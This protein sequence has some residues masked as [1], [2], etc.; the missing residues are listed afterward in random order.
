MKNTK[1][2]KETGNNYVRVSANGTSTGNNPKINSQNGSSV[3][4]DFHKIK[5][6]PINYWCGPHFLFHI[7]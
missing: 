6:N 7:N 5:M 1:I 4:K 2:E 3:N